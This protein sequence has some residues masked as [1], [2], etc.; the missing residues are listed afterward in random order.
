M[1]NLF[2]LNDDFVGAINWVILFF[3]GMDSKHGFIVTQYPTSNTLA[4]FWQ[5]VHEQKSHVIVLLSD[6]AN[7]E[8]K[9]NFFPN[10]YI[11]FWSIFG[12]FIERG[13][14]SLLII[15]QHADRKN[16]N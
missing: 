15:S 4:D 16:I 6:M 1:W 3:Q 12:V 8:H 2:T 5:M 13:L 11:I 10:I 9:V 14:F 7:E